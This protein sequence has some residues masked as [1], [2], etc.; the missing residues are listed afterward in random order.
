MSAAPSSIWEGRLVRLRAIEPEDWEQYWLDTRDTES[1]RLGYQ[2]GFPRSTERAKRFANDRTTIDGTD[3]MAFFWAI[4]TLGGTL[5]GS[6]NTHGVDSRNGHFEYGIGIF[7]PQWG[8]GYASDAIRVIMRYYFQEL[9]F[10]KV[11]ATVYAFNEGSLALHRKLGFAEEG[12]IRQSIYSD[13]AFHDEFWFGMTAA[14]FRERY[15]GG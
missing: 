12:C 3:T 1:A 13:G 5:V 2:V 11:N 7:R 4:E 10:N 9:R 8:H 15:P 14:E 6:C